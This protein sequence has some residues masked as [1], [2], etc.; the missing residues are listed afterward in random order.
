MMLVERS[1]GRARRL[2]GI[3]LDLFSLPA[4]YDI[5]VRDFGLMLGALTLGGLASVYDRR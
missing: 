2:E 1:R 5:V 3:V 4:W